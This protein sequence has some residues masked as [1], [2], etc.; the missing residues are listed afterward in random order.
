MNAVTDRCR[1]RCSTAAAQV[2]CGNRRLLILKLPNRGHQLRPHCHIGAKRPVCK[3]PAESMNAV[4]GGITKS[5]SSEI[6]FDRRELNS[7]LPGHR[8][9]PQRLPYRPTSAPHTVPA[10]FASLPDHSPTSAVATTQSPPSRG[11]TLR[12]SQRPLLRVPS[13]RRLLSV[14]RHCTC[15]SC[16]NQTA[17]A[18]PA[19]H[20]SSAAV[21]PGPRPIPP[22]ATT[23]FS[24]SNNSTPFDLLRPH[25]AQQAD[26]TRRASQSRM[27]IVLRGISVR[28]KPLHRPS[29]RII[30]R[31]P[32]SIPARAPPW[33]WSQTFSCAPCG[34]HRESPAVRAAASFR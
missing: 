32:A 14:G 1:I 21:R 24:N 31:A 17:L 6:G 12:R 15:Y 11:I 18:V 16:R 10:T 5:A 7:M 34:P 20:Q 29:K 26:L 13:R 30:H 25:S 19:D 2:H 9:Q 27:A 3:L 33:R 8:E 23:A 22:T 28:L 4:N